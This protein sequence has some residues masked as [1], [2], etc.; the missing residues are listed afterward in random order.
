M[1]IHFVAIGGAIMHALALSMKD[2]GFQVTG[3]DDHIFD[4]AKSNLEKAGILPTEMGFFESNIT[5]D[6]DAI[7]LGMHAR[8]DN[9]ELK[10]AQELGLKI[11]SFPQYVYENS[12]DKL[13]IV[14]A[15]SHGKTTITSMIMHVLNFCHKDFD[16]VVG[17]QLKGFATNVRLSDKAPIIIIEGDEYLSSAIHFEPKFLSYKPD[18]AIISGIAWDHINVFPVYEDYVKQFLLFSESIEPNGSLIYCEEDKEVVRVVDMV[19]NSAIKIAYH[20]PAFE[21]IDD[22]SYL[23][24]K[25]RKVPLSIIGK[26]N[27]QNLMA[28]KN[29]CVQAGIDETVFYEA[30]QS[31]EGAANRLTLVGKNDKT[32]IYKDFAHSPSK[33]KATVSAVKQQF[34]QRKLVAVMELHTFS[35]LSKDFLHEYKDSMAQADIAIVF[36]SPEVLAL[37]KLSMITEDD[38]RQGFHRDN[39]IVFSS[40]VM[41][42][43]F[44]RSQDWQ[45]KNLLLMSSGNFD[46]MNITGISDSIL[47]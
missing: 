37:K 14:V 22:V 25:D 29:A 5:K 4:P 44:I 15:G 8:K 36:Y 21:I 7:I 19:K 2:K 24:L 34:S 32:V 38:I 11:Y 1:R 6:I 18:I 35:S 27:L 13:R 16:Y 17:S 43:N 40:K 39:L 3:S 10:K 42:E 28:A 47:S 12:K 9:I 45:M 46:G 23:I 31:F 26:H 30:I 41:L 20:T 33:L